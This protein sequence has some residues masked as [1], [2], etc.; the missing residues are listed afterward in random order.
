MKKLYELPLGLYEKALPYTD[1][2]LVILSEAKNLGFSFVEISIDESKER[3]T[4]LS[5]SQQRIRT[6]I[7]AKFKTGMR[8]PSMCLSCH[9]SYPFGSAL[10]QTR[11]KAFDIMR[12]A[13]DLADKIGVRVI[14]LAGYDVYYEPSHKKSPEYFLEG[15]RKSEDYAAGAQVMLGIEIMDTAFMNSVSKYLSLKKLAESPW[16]AVYPDVGNLSAWNGAFSRHEITAGIHETVGIHL[17]DTYA[18][19]EHYQGQFRD[20]P[21][22]KGCVDF[23]TV[24]KTLIEAH[25]QG[26]FVVEMWA[27]ADLASARASVLQAKR[28]LSARMKAAHKKHRTTE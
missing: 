19:S 7:E 18:V 20:V 24:F 27:R 25:Y 17:K 21:F 11:V 26:P 9:R 5:W 4:R 2:W 8:V 3:I 15:I 6:F 10:R 23:V 16:F 1:D 22:G 28:W 13:V 12:R 14:Q